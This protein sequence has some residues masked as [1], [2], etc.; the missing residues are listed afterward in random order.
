MTRPLPTLRASAFAFATLAVLATG[1][2]RAAEEPAASP[3]DMARFLAG[4]PADAASPLAAYNKDASW[5]R[6]A[7][8]MD[9]T[10][11]SLNQRQISRIQAWSKAN[12]AVRQPTTFYMFSG[13]DFL[14]ANAFFPGSNTYVMSGLEPVGRMPEAKFLSRRT[15]P[16]IVG[17][18]QASIRSITNVSFFLTKEMRYQLSST[19]FNGTLPILSAFIARADKTITDVSYLTIEADGAP[20][21]SDG[22]PKA[23]VPNGVKITFK[24]KDAQDGDAQTL[25]YFS[26]DVS[27]GGLKT[28]GF[29]KFC[30]G[31]APGDAFV[32]SASYLMH[33]D[34]FSSVREFLLQ[35]ASAIVQDDT[36]V[37]VRFFKREDWEVRPYGRYL[38]PI[39]L[40]YGRYQSQMAE[41]FRKGQSTPIDFGVGYRWRPNESNLIIATKQQKKAEGK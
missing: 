4:L 3:N 17:H 12:L 19:Q 14:Y 31:L 37:P 27:N 9:A 30:E 13:P 10:W 23:G 24:D 7:Q 33:S 5:M 26:T 34:S 36:G 38:G 39:P 1:A 16:G 41:L 20:K 2:A 28:S 11:R 29:L 21:P 32:K 25:Y 18:L 8:A 40:F 22:T 6:H 15:V 35:Q